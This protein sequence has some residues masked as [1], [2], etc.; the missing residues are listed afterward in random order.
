MTTLSPEVLAHLAT[1]CY[2]GKNEK[3]RHEGMGIADEL[4]QS[5][6]SLVQFLYRMEKYKTR[7]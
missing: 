7:E 6:N 3:S 2:V 5:L 4:A 1:R